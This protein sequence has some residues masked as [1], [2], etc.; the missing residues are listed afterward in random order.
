[1]PEPIQNPQTASDQDNFLPKSAPQVETGY[2]R[3][4]RDLASGE[5]TRVAIK[6][7]PTSM[8]TRTQAI[9]EGP[10]WDVEEFFSGVVEECSDEGVRVGVQSS[11]GE[12]AT[13]WI[14]WREIDERE[15]DYA[16]VGAPVRVSILIPTSGK[17]ERAKRV[18]FLRPTQWRTR[19]Q[20]REAAAS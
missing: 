1:M 15:R 16:I 13:A 6:Q 11:A 20:H 7:V 9:D 4:P 12:E 10:N 14:P 3:R 18:R 8:A 17:R 2:P 19:K 5:D